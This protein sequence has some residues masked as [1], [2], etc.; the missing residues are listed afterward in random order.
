MIITAVRKMWQLVHRQ[1]PFAVMEGLSS[2][3]KPPVELG[4]VEEQLCR[5]TLGLDIVSQNILCPPQKMKS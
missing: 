1:I 2:K 3:K 5:N 4:L